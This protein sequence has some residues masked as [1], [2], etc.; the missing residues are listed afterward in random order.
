MA[1]LCIRVHIYVQRVSNKEESLTGSKSQKWGVHKIKEDQF[2]F[3]FDA[4][5]HL[6]IKRKAG[7]M[8]LKDRKNIFTKP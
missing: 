7:F 6:F 1:D 5:N 4:S 3:S 2:L 8:K